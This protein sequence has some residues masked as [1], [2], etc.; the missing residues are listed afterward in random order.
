MGGIDE[1][2]LMLSSRS[3]EYGKMSQILSWYLL[4]VDGLIDK[5]NSLQ[6]EADELRGELAEAN[7]RRDALE[8]E[9]EQLAY[10]LTKVRDCLND[11]IELFCSTCTDKDENTDKCK[12][13][14]GVCPC[15]KR[16]KDAVEESQK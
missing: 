1:L 7:G 10:R 8:A 11:A 9:N 14:D 12:D 2:K 3:T 15:V 16:W 6:S 5:A 4:S 13:K